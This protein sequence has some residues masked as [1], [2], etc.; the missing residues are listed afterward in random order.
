MI[1]VIATIQLAAGRRAGFLD[2]FHKLMP[3]VHAET[4]CVEYGPGIDLEHG[5][6]GQP[7]VRDDVVTVVEKW[8]TLPELH[9]HLASPHM[10][11]YRK[12]VSDMVT[13]VEIRVLDP[14]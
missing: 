1:H 3:L 2:E 6:P 5:I 7:S 11:A 10:I 4:G 9:A 12:T 14:A 13:G 8:E